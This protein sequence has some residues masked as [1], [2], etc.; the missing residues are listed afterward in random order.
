MNV[1]NPELGYN[2]RAMKFVLRTKFEQ[3]PA[4]REILLKTG[5]EDL[6]ENTQIATEEINKDA[7]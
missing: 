7:F 5:N 2:I 6:I 3:N 4:L 1:Y